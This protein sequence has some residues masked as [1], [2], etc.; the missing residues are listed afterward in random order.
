MD[1]FRRV[2]GWLRPYRKKLAICIVLLSAME[3][4]FEIMDTKPQVFDKRDDLPELPPIRGE[5]TFDHVQGNPFF[6]LFHVI[7]DFRARA[8]QAHIAFHDIE[9]LRQFVDAVFP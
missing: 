3:R 9:Q 2:L 6:E 4:I 7:R 5:I 1:T 8:D